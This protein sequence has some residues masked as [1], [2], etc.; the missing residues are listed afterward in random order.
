MPYVSGIG[1]SIIV[2]AVVK[3]RDSFVTFVV[4]SVVLGSLSPSG[5]TVGLIVV[6][7]AHS[8]G[9]GQHTLGLTFK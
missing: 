3:G 5:K 8:D 4:D 9:S 6:N 2:V 1:G 7:V